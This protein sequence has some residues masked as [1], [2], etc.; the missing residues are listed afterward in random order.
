V[1]EDKQGAIDLVHNPVHHRRTK[2]V[3]V[4]YHY[5]RQA[6][7]AGVVLVMRLLD[8]PAGLLVV[9][10]SQLAEDDELAPALT[11]RRLR[12]AVATTERRLAG[13]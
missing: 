13:A 10:A 1:Y 2:H 5:I 9:I 7:A 3:D 8:L 12:V 6:E 4:K 11:C